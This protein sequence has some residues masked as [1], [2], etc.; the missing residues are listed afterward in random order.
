MVKMEKFSEFITEEKD[1]PYKLLVLSHDDPLDP[2]ETGPMIKKK[3]SEM[4]LEVYLTEFSGM[5]ME[6]KGKDQLVYSFP[7]NEKG[8]AQIPDMKDEVNVLSA[9][10][11][12]E[13]AQPWVG[14]RPPVS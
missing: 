7:V 1:E 5:Y 8:Q 10:S 3:A 9:S 11:A 12:F 2:N 6:D 14:R 4:G 13:E